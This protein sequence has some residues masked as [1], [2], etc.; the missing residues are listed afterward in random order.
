M[1]GLV[2]A[3]LL[4]L[5]SGCASTSSAATG[6]GAAARPADLGRLALERATELERALFDDLADGRL[7]AFDLLEA[8]LVVSGV[9]DRA[10][11]E[12]LHRKAVAVE[13][14][15]RVAG[16]K[17]ERARAEAL[18]VAMHERLLGRYDRAQSSVAVTVRDGVY[19]CVAATLLY[20]ALALRVGLAAGAVDLPTHVYTR[21]KLDGR[22]VDVET[23]HPRGFEP[24]RSDA[25]YQRFLEQRGLDSGLV[26][27]EDGR[28]AP[29]G[30]ARRH[31]GPERP[32][33]NLEVL[34]YVY[35]NAA[36]IAL[37]RGDHEAAWVLFA[38]ASRVV[39]GD[40]TY[41]H[42]RDALLHNLALGHL[43]RGDHAAGMRLV[44]FALDA[45]A[46]GASA[47]KWRR[48]AVVGYA[49]LAER[50]VAAGDAPALEAALA[51]ARARVPGDALLAHNG[52]A[53][54][55]QLALRLSEQGQRDAASALLLRQA[56]A[57][58]RSEGARALAGTY[59]QLVADAAIADTEAGRHDAAVAEV[60]RGLRAVA[61][62]AP[63][64]EALAQLLSLKGLA[65]FRARRFAVAAEACRASLA[66][67]ANDTTRRNLFASLANLAADAYRAKD[68]AAALQFAREALAVQDDPAL[69]DLERA[70]RR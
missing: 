17:G 44:T 60:D 53:W 8:S 15:A 55:Q 22:E 31:A 38:K 9:P 42:N 14:D 62:Y 11:L 63:P 56:A 4:A 45:E 19:N 41:R 70:C 34:S 59:L 43:Q 54:T 68:C 36:A 58:G 40:A 47:A 6:A 46:D 12:A 27:A 35:A 57:T 51:Q 25:D 2:F 66:L 52:V 64:A 10:A 61:A 67:H 29:R 1:R 69:R 16:A 37:D 30:V 7:D 21:L 39:P 28:I 50:A 18:F 20:N 13:A 3:A 24:F 49:G 23:T 65:H 26:A 32:I 33:G 48:L 5:L